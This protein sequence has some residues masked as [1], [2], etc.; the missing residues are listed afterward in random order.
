MKSAL[1]TKILRMKALSLTVRFKE[2]YESYIFIE[3]QMTRQ[4]KINFIV[5]SIF[6][7]ELNN[8]IHNEYSKRQNI[9]LQI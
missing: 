5:F 3:M 4:S 7:R 1:C 6:L 2:F 8:S 9:I